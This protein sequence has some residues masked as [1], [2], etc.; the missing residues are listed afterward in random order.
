MFQSI[1]ELLP[2]FSQIVDN[3][4]ITFHK[5]DFVLKISQGS[6]DGETRLVP[7]PWH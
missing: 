6:H 3:T 2:A 4:T 7:A 5:E 1:D